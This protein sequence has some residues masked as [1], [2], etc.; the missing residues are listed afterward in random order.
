M[1][2]RATAEDVPRIAQMAAYFVN[3]S[4][5][6]ELV[7]PC[8]VTMQENFDV[9]VGS[10]NG[11]AFVLEI[12]GAV[13]GAIIGL[14]APHLMTGGTVALELGWWVEPKVRGRNGLELLRA[15]EEA[16]NASTASLSVMTCPPDGSERVGRIYE[17]AGYRK[18][19]ATY[20]RAIP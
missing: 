20:M 2:R 9:I 7:S 19:E 8:N 1:I 11:I 17:Q 18:M 4:S 3:N 5:Y 14:L 15:Y 13:E 10:P 16:V 12:D 6:S